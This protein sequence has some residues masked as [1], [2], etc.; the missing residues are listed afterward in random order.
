[1]VPIRQYKAAERVGSVDRHNKPQ[2]KGKVKDDLRLV[3][4]ERSGELGN[5]G[6]EEDIY[7]V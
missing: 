3:G 6:E 2:S 4:L 5:A 7:L 1:M